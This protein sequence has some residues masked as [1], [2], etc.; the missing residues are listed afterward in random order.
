MSFLA[1]LFLAGLVVLGVPVLIHLIQ[2]ERHRVVEF[3]S[4][5]FLRRIPYRSVRRRRIRHWA[6][7]AIRL[8]ALAAIVLAFAR[9]FLRG[10]AV[11]SGPSAGAREVVVLL[12]RSYSMGY[13]DRWS[14]ARAA[15]REA[16]DGLG[17]ADRASLVLFATDAEVRVRP[18]S[19]RGRLLAEVAAAT[20]G[21]GATRYAA[22]LRLAG[23]LL[24]ESRLPRREAILISDFQRI[25]W[26]GA[27][28]VRLPAGAKLT[29]RPVAREPTAN[30]AVTPVSL[31]RSTFSGQARITVTAGVTNHGS[32][33]VTGLDAA[34]EIGGRVVQTRRIDVV[35][36]G[37]ASIAF[38]PVT[39]SSPD[40]RATVRIAP[41]ALAA[42]NAFYFVVSPAA[43]LAVVLVEPPGAPP[44]AS[45]YLSRALAIGDT[46]RV[47]V[48]VR[49]ADTLSEDV[50]DRAAVVVL[51]D[52]P[53][54]ASL[55]G[56]LSRFVEHGG[57]LLVAAGRR[58]TWPTGGPDILPGVARAFLDRGRGSPARLGVIDYAHA[59]FE[60]FR[61]PRS[62]DFSAARFYGHRAIT[63]RS[64]ATVLARFEDGTPALVERRVGAGRVMMWGCTLDLSWSDLPVKPVFLP[65]VH[66][67]VRYLAA[68]SA[69]VPWIT[70][71]EVVD[72]AR[73]AGEP[74][75]AGPPPARVVV[76][77]SGRRLALGRD[78]GSGVVELT[79]QGFYEIHAP[80]G[81]VV[82]PTVVASNV[83]LSESDLTP[84]DPSEIVVRVG[85][86][87][88]DRL[89]SAPPT[90]EAREALQRL[91]WY[92]LL[93]GIVL[94]AADTALADRL[95]KRVDSGFTEGRSSVV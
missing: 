55:A 21:A 71:G 26:P 13:G 73:R 36:G 35:G 69:P 14:R 62:G 9:P 51:D 47:E 84:I 56:R 60:P 65:L 33:P 39:V 90:P 30:V 78:E 37:A 87:E 57:G 75:A 72:P 17:P 7:L 66:R 63:P 83:D 53:V 12:D 54:P 20:P 23:T 49:D 74:P 10:E 61:A 88:R 31:E 15:A 25:A 94:L 91:W 59:V 8:A 38:A 28:L 79:E 43:A 3:P 29:P 95:S 81:T 34:L 42:D 68:Y 45:L 50:I 46:P 85:G 93:A 19:D 32:R 11:A 40:T 58:A 22:A 4:L 24:G 70:V 52:V 5:M 86:G 48:A 80:A 1:P 16:I 6:L 41:D 44:G 82:P 92:L 77:P 18:T 76:S 27:D 67:V 89:D 2:R 64:G